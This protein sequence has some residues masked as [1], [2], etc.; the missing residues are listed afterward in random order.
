[1]QVSELLLI[2]NQL[3]SS[4]EPEALLKQV[5]TNGPMSH[6]LDSLG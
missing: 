1:M 4:V 2:K 5:P 3:I 6:S